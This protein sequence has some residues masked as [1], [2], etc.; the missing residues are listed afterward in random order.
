MTIQNLDV[1]G[2]SRGRERSLEADQLT[3]CYLDLIIKNPLLCGLGLPAN[4]LFLSY[5][6]TTACGALA[7][8]NQKR[9]V[10]R[11]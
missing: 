9:S 5:V 6:G 11:R 7:E 4:H 2:T 10:R 3:R 8:P 1:H